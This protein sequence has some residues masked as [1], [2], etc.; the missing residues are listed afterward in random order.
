L[1]CPR[2]WL[3]W[4][5]SLAPAPAA[6]RPPAAAAAAAPGFGSSRHILG[7]FITIIISGA[8]SFCFRR[9]LLD[10]NPLLL[11]LILLLGIAAWGALLLPRSAGARGLHPG[12]PFS[13]CSPFLNPWT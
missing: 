1:A 4:R 3:L 10:I 7:I 11:L 5:S 6:A 12:A 9:Y 2:P 13:P 8:D